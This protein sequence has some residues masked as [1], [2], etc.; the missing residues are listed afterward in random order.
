MCQAMCGIAGTVNW[1]DQ[2]VVQ[3]MTNALSHRGPDDAG[4][5][6]FWPERVGLGH[7]RLSIIDVSAAGHQPMRA[8]KGARCVVFNGE[9]YNFKELRRELE[10]QG[11]RFRSNT[12]TE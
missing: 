5:V 11:H 1:G 10:G 4:V 2:A 8:C 3:R 9:I 7:R 6:F 12:D